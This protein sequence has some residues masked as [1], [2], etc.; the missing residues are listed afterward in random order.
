MFI[1]PENILQVSQNGVKSIRE[2]ITSIDRNSN[3]LFQKLGI[4]IP[5]IRL[6]SNISQQ[7]GKIG[8]NR[9]LMINQIETKI[10]DPNSDLFK[11]WSRHLE[12]ARND[13]KFTE[14]A[15]QGSKSAESIWQ[16]M[17]FLIAELTTDG[18][19]LPEV[20][21][22]LTSESEIEPIFLASSTRVATLKMESDCFNIQTQRVL[23]P[24]FR[25]IGKWLEPP[26]QSPWIDELRNV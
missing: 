18:V 4:K 7:G 24:A 22:N 10:F 11:L 3:G 13:S 25:N 19:F 12:L 1:N 15:W 23:I 20:M 16:R 8:L 21:R 2:I 26:E 17:R 6:Q 9:E 5:K 14:T